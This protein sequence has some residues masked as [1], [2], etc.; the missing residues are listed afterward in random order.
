MRIA[1]TNALGTVIVD[2]PVILT[3]FSSVDG[4]VPA[5]EPGQSVF[6]IAYADIMRNRE[7]EFDV[8]TT[9]GGTLTIEAVD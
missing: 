6:S 3:S 1:I 9:M 5:H 8:K 2:G 4:G 7:Q